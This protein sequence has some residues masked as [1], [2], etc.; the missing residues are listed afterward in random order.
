M[1]TTVQ[2]AGVTALVDSRCT[3]SIMDI[4]WVRSIGLELML[5]QKLISMTNMD[6]TQNKEGPIKYGIDLALMVGDHQER[7]HFLL[8]KSKTYKMILGHDWLR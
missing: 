5:L 7:L 8:R 6:G 2:W 3:N 4:H 1:L